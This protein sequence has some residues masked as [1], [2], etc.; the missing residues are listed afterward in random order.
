MASDS[1]GDSAE[2]QFLATVAIDNFPGAPL[3]FDKKTGGDV[4]SNPPKHR[5]GGMCPEISYLA[6]PVYSDITVSRVYVQQR[7]QVL[8]GELDP[9]CGTTYC[10]VTETPLTATGAPA[11]FVPRT[12]RGRLANIKPGNVDSTSNTPRMWEM[13]VVVESVA[14]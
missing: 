7:D 13:D 14:N 6:L 4:T 1:I 10:T 11:A 12:Y 2:L 5:P 8:I 3:V 9:L